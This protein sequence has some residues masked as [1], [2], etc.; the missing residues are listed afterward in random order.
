MNMLLI[1]KNMVY[2]EGLFHPVFDLS[3]LTKP[4]FL[5]LYLRLILEKNFIENIFL[6]LKKFEENNIDELTC[7][8]KLLTFF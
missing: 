6:P 5:N 8:K 3:S 2:R 4:L 1:Q 7:N